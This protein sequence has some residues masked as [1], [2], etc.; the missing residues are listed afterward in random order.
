MARVALVVGLAV[1]GMTAL[2]AGCAS[3]EHHAARD[4]QHRLQVQLA[5][6]LA[7]HQVALQSRPDGAVVSL[8]QDA[9]FVPGQPDLTVQGRFTMASVAESL[10]DPRLMRV[11]VGNAS[12]TPGNLQGQRAETIQQYIESYSLGPPLAMQAGEPVASVSAQQAL[13]IAIQVQCPPGPQGSTWKHQ[14]AG[15]TCN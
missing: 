9:M 6:E 15:P 7:N 10:L 12:E 3:P 1:A 13:A 5:P 8:D 11:A 2:V 14:V 4:L